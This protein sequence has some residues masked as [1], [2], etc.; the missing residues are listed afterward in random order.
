MGPICP[1]GSP[2]LL[3]AGVFIGLSNGALIALVAIGYTLVYGIIELINFSHGD[4]FMLGTFVA[5]TVLT[6]MGFAT[7]TGTTPWHALAL[8]LIAAMLFCGILNV[9]AERIAYRRLRNAPRLAPLISAIGVSFIYLNI[10]LFWRGPSAVRFPDLLPTFDLVEL[11]TGAQTLIR[12]TSKDAMVMGTAIPL[13]LGLGWIIKNTKMGKAMRAVAQDR[14]MALQMGIDVNRVIA[15]TFLLGGMLAGAAALMHGL[16]NGN[17]VFTLGFTAGLK[18]FTAAVLG[19][20]GNVTGAALGGILLGLLGA[21]TVTCYGGEW[22]NVG[23]FSI[24]VLILVFRPTGLLGE[25]T[26]ER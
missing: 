9:L 2:E 7:E 20:I 3:A 14:E 10:G 13:M 22:E 5:L 15:F 8:A 26:P 21:M 24:L 4:L 25:Q 11:F 18:A 12:F 16:Y 23:V 1:G 6:A 17:T 19:G